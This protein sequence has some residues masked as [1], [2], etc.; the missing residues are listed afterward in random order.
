RRRRSG[1]ASSS[2]GSS[3]GAGGG[4]HEGASHRFGSGRHL[5]ERTGRRGCITDDAH[6]RRFALALEPVRIAVLGSVVLRES[7]A[8]P[9]LAVALTEQR[10]LDELVLPVPADL[11]AD[12][13]VHVHHVADTL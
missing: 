11:L 10:K 3:S 13:T 9:G 6:Q 2:V 8:H 4:G 5:V 7:V 12:R 1:W